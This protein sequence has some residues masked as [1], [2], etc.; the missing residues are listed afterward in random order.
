MR[1]NVRR[2]CRMW[3]IQQSVSVADATCGQIQGAGTN[4]CHKITELYQKPVPGPGRLEQQRECPLKFLAVRV[5]VNEIGQAEARATKHTADSQ[6]SR[7]AQA[8]AIGA[9]FSSSLP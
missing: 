8:V 3:G 4:P 9:S 6:A 7:N 1:G 2:F 5:G